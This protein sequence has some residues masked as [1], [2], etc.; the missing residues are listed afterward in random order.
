LNCPFYQGTLKE[1]TPPGW[2]LGKKSTTVEGAKLAQFMS[3]SLVGRQGSLSEREKHELASFDALPFLI[4]S[5]RKP[6]FRSLRI[7]TRRVEVLE[8]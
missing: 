6:F 4:S 2:N 5:R 7:L 1:K 3:A 8:D